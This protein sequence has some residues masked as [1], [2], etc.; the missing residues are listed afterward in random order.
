MSQIATDLINRYYRAFNDGN[1][2][3]FL[4]LL[5]ADV[6]HDINEGGRETGR[7][8]FAAFMERMNRHYRE[9]LTDI[10]VFA[11]ADGHR[12]AAEFI[13]NGEYLSSDEGLP[14][15]KGQRYTLP[16]GAFF[17]IRDGKIARVTNYYNLQN[18]IKQVSQ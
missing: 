4:D 13:V 3:M 7:E 8:A 14:E 12:A 2:T 18:W 15:A 17:E 1:M 11:S 10:V 5:T 6:V 9:R 16:A